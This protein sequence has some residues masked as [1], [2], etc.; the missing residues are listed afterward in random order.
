MN[1]P[2][3]GEALIR[4]LLIGIKIGEKFGPVMKIG[5]LPDSFG[6]T[7]QL[8]PQILKG[9]GIDSVVGMRGVPFSKI[10]SSEFEWRGLNGDVILGVYLKEGY[11]NACFLPED[12]QYADER[13]F[14]W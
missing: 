10:N 8:P 9:F 11:F 4:N 5:Y 13:V 2:P 7:C 3:D 14:H 6:H 1:F 12:Y